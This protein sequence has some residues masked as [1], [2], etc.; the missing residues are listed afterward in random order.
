MDAKCHYNWSINL[1]YRRHFALLLQFPGN[2]IVA[3]DGPM[4]NKTK[5]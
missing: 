3:I 2:D 5:I 1:T 4:I